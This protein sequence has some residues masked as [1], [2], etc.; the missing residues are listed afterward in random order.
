MSRQPQAQD[1]S[2]IALNRKAKHNYTLETHFEAGVVLEGWEVKSIRAGKIQLAESYVVFQRG[3][4][5]L[6]NAHISPLHSASTHIQADARRSRKLL[7]HQKELSQ[8]YGHV[9][10]KG[11]TLV[12]CR[13][14]WKKHRVK[15]D[16]ALAK[17][18]KMHDKRAST[19]EREWARE[20]ERVF[21]RQRN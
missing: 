3:A 15:L 17:G 16:I 2:T 9:E 1:N 5:Y 20:K 12:A 10:R 4:L 7:L 13:M 11:Y 8:L 21:K 19:K 14:Y 18:K 6:I